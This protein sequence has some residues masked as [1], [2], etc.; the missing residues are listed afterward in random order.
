KECAIT[1]GRRTRRAR[2]AVV[3]ERG[4]LPEITRYNVVEEAC[5]NCRACTTGT[6]CPGLA[7]IDPPLG[8]KIGIDGEGC[9]D[10]G[11]C[12]RLKACPSFE[13]VTVRRSKAPAPPAIQDVAPPTDPVLPS[14]GPEGYAVYM[15][16]VGGMGIG[17]ASRILTEAAAAAFPEVDT[18]HKKGLA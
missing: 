18:Y 14:V 6:G 5:E 3:R 9:V 17:V 15:A 12:A 16:G 4:F 8:E 2:E 7:V 13:L 11:H 10:D 1:S